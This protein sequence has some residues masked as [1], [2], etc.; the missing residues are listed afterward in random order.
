MDNKIIFASNLKNYMK[1]NGKTRREV[2]DALG[3]SYNTFSDWVNAKKYPRIDKVEMLADYFG[4]KKSDLIE[5]NV[6]PEIQKLNPEDIMVDIVFVDIAVRM[7]SDIF[8][9]TVV[10]KNC[11]NKNFFELS[12]MLCELSDEQLQAVKSM[13]GTLIDKSKREK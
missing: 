4:I 13:L 7:S 12:E 3:V 11:Y 1:L 6:T 2:S 5:E 8:F 10:K 9:R